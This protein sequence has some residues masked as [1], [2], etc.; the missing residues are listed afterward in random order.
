MTPTD[1]LYKALDCG[2]GVFRVTLDTEHP[3]L[4]AHFPGRAVLPGAVMMDMVCRLAQEPGKRLRIASAKAVKFLSPLFPAE[5]GSFTVN[6]ERQ[7]D[8]SV[9]AAVTEGGT[10]FA[11]MTLRLEEVMP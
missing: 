8:G 4:K 5:C 11:R 9:K 3:V 10:V 6:M 2:N 1:S 7:P